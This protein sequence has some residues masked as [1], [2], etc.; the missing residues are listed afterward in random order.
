MNMHAYLCCAHASNAEVCPFSVRSHPLVMPIHAWCLT[1]LTV[2]D[3][4]KLFAAEPVRFPCAAWPAWLSQW[5]AQQSLAPCPALLSFPEPPSVAA[6]SACSHVNPLQSL[7]VALS[8]S[9]LMHQP[10]S[11]PFSCCPFQPDDVSTLS[12]PFY[13][14]LCSLHSC[15][16]LEPAVH[17][18]KRPA[19]EEAYSPMN[20]CPSLWG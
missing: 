15:Q 5:H 16:P 17:R 1:V 14:Y 2:P 8:F 11:F 12:T 6:P 10:S 19:T 20:P 4:L 9:L 13:C 7:S 18:V 3:Q